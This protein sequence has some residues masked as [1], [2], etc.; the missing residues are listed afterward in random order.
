MRQPANSKRLAILD[1][2]SR[3]YLPVQIAG[4]LEVSR[5]Y[6]HAVLGRLVA[7]LLRDRA[8]RLRDLHNSY[9]RAW[10]ALDR[11]RRDRRRRQHSR[12]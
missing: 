8:K 12:T 3:G 7:G 5:Q 9:R 4:E 2:A 10:P 6:V 1:L 11:R